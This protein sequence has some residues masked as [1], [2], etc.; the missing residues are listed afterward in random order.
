MPQ[1]KLHDTGKRSI[2]RAAIVIDVVSALLTS[3][4]SVVGG[5]RV[6]ELLHHAFAASDVLE[7]ELRSGAGASTSAAATVG[8]GCAHSHLNRAR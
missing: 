6:L 4:L 1:S 7:S 3:I 5:V 2:I 8:V